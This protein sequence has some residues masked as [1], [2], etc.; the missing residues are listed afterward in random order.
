VRRAECQPSRSSVFAS[1]DTDGLR[2]FDA[3]RGQQPDLAGVLVIPDGGALSSVEYLDS[4]IS[5]C[6]EKP[7]DLDTLGLLIERLDASHTQVE[8]AVPSV[9]TFADQR[10]ARAILCGIHDLQSIGSLPAWG[11]KAGCAE[12]TLGSWCKAAGTSAKAVED[13]R[14]GLAAG[15]AAIRTSVSPRDL[16]GYADSRSI[17]RFIERVGPLEENGQP[18]TPSDYCRN[19][20]ALP[21]KSVIDEVVRLLK[22]RGLIRMVCAFLCDFL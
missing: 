10:L 3:L 7:F 4:R 22:L 18:W 12:S 14:R 5:A 13:F 15:I 8:S 1:P 2:L 9:V 19:Q 17:Q 20:R 6:V 21:K 11:R 16:L